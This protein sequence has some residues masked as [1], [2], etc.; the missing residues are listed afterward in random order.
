M[1][2]LRWA[3]A[4]SLLFCALAAPA[5]AVTQ[6]VES[7]TAEQQQLIERCRVY[8]QPFC[9][10]LGVAQPPQ[11][12][13]M[14]SDSTAQD[15]R[16]ERCRAYWQPSCAELGVPNPEGT[17]SVDSDSTEDYRLERC[18]ANWQPSCAGLGVPNPQDTPSL[19]DRQREEK[20]REIQAARS[21]LEFGPAVVGFPNPYRFSATGFIRSSWPVVIRYQI[22]AGATAILTV[23]PQ[24]GGGRP[25]D[26]ALPRSV[27]GSPQLYR[28]EA[29][30]SDSDD[31]LVVASFAITAHSYSSTAGGE[32]SAPVKILGFGA[33]ERA[34]G[35]VAIDQIQY[36]PPTVDKPRDNG[37]ILLTYRYLLKNEW[38]RVAEDLW[39]DCPGSLLCQLQPRSY[40][41]SRQGWKQWQWYV[42][43]GTKSGLYQLKI[44]AWKT[45]GALADPTAYQQCGG[46]ADWVI[47]SAG[48]ILVGNQ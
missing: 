22:P 37:T 16:I 3:M 46:E 18:R 19:E 31:R 35:S 10:D 47:G 17:A 42:N 48:P 34:V 40:R 27:D 38:D 7:V 32:V 1:A 11:P 23:T 12:S 25:F 29:D 43:R 13:S 9:S 26:V 6:D 45:C 4:L 33:G 15:Y 20:K 21:L 5:N 30:V 39:R 28:F 36:D 8:W 14:D 44:R 2:D 41:P 24:Y